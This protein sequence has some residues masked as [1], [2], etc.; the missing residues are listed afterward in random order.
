MITARVSVP[1]SL[2][3][4]AALA[5][6]AGAPKPA[7]ADSAPATG[8]ALLDSLLASYSEDMNDLASLQPPEGGTPVSSRSGVFIERNPP[9]DPSDQPADPAADPATTPEQTGAAESTAVAGA[10]AGPDVEALA[11]ELAAA[12]RRR[13]IGGV[14]PYEDLSRVAMLEGIAPG[15]LQGL[16]DDASSDS[17]DLIAVLA[18]SE[19]EAL[20][21]ARRTAR[22][23][24][25]SESADP[26]MAA[27][28]LRAAAQ[29]L[30]E[31]QVIRIRKTVL[32][33]RVDGF[34]RYEPFESST[35]LAGRSNRMIV[36]AEVDRFRQRPVAETPGALGASAAGRDG[37]FVVSLTQSLNLYFS[38]GGLLVWRRPPQTVSDYSTGRFR[39]FYL[40]DTIDLP[41][42]L[43][44]GSY[45]LK[46]VVRDEATGEQAESIIPIA[47]VADPGLA[48]GG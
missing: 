24:A 6:C 47:L 42:T 7:N 35:F 45:S 8:D 39:D 2:A 38:E 32:C 30:D 14:S 44:A 10:P 27:D 36:Y 3:V 16:G 34:A 31:S 17:A 37:R 4:L 18:P 33:W 15:V 9:A 11:R 43:A 12:L 1:S 40:I 13:A 25:A 20:R 29:S 19:R 48:R 22:M 41:S 21:A 46:V 5:G 28:A 26:S 23:L